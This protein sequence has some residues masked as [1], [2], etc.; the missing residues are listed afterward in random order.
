[1]EVDPRNTS[2][3]CPCCG[4]IDERTDRIKQL[5]FVSLRPQQAADFN[6]ASNIRAKA[7]VTPPQV[8]AA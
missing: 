4:V 1:M 8:L 5:S 6:A 3:A 2:Q 7:P